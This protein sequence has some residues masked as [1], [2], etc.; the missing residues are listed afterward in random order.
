MLLVELEDY[1]VRPQK[2]FQT[3]YRDTVGNLLDPVQ[4]QEQYI[5]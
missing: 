4:N 2:L 5:D 3:C 1:Y